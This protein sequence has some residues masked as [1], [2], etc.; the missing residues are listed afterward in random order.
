MGDCFAYLFNKILN[1]RGTIN[2]PFH[3]NK[4]EILLIREREAAINFFFL[5]MIKLFSSRTVSSFL[6]KSN[7]FHLKFP[8]F[9]NSSLI[10]IYM[11]SEN[12]N[13]RFKWA[14][15]IQFEKLNKQ[16]TLGFFAGVDFR[17]L[18]N[19]VFSSIWNS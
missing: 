17:Q 8:N 6:E 19:F 14:E 1:Q 11:T 9:D 7:K 16:S 2:F 18:L 12:L 13:N 15:L 3:K 10:G 5:K 4:N